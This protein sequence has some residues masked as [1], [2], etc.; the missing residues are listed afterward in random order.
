V[1]ETN[2]PRLEWDEN[3]NE[4]EQFGTNLNVRI[5]DQDDTYKQMRYTS[6]QYRTTYDARR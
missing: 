3:E 6:N 5:A 1:Q 2:D 4:Q